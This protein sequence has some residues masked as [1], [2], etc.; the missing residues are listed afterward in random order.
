MAPLES[1]QAWGPGHSEHSARKQSL[2]CNAKA[3]RELGNRV[4]IDRM[5]FLELA[6]GSRAEYPVLWK[7][8]LSSSH[9]RSGRQPCEKPN[10]ADAFFANGAQEGWRASPVSYMS[11]R[12]PPR[13]SFKG[14]NAAGLVRLLCGECQSISVSSMDCFFFKS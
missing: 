13:R 14:E 5:R 9:L 10:M 4:Q 2:P 6:E 11:C 8:A 12:E 1:H 7:K 3:S